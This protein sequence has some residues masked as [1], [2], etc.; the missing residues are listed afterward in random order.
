[1][2]R[3]KK[4]DIE[5]TDPVTAIVDA[6]NDTKDE[7]RCVSLGEAHRV[8]KALS[9]GSLIADL[10]LGG[11]FQC[12]RLVHIYGPEAS[13]KSTFLQACAIS[14]QKLDIPIVHYDTEHSADPVYMRTQGL[15][16]HKTIEIN[17]KNVPAY[18]YAQPETGEGVYKHLH[19][20]LRR[21][22]DVNL[23][24]INKPSCLILLDSVAAMFSKSRDVET[25]EGAAGLEARMHSR[26][27]GVTK[28]LLA[29]KGA[30]MIASNQ[31]RMNINMRMPGANPEAPTGGQ[32][33]KYYPDY[34]IR[35]HGRKKAEE[36]KVGMY[37]Q[38][39]WV[40]TIKNKTFPAF[41][42]FEL[43]IIMGKGIDKA[44]D[45]LDFLEAI[46][47][48][49]RKQGKNKILLKKFFTD[50]YLAWDAFRKVAESDEFRN[51]CFSLLK[52]DAVYRRH[53]KLLGYKNY[54]LDGTDDSVEVEGE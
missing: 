16:I 36:D 8:D 43:D 1:M 13:G 48:V 30:I 54:A 33:W 20:F 51:Y 32:A 22:P 19:R 3:K 26:F 31:I 38:H 39:V 21:L 15:D 46:G 44:Q 11:G 35:V 7:I 6:F 14:G 23:H 2:P 42:E 17:G 34:A 10:K 28:S 52:K 25:G 53:F 27:L 9:T 40:R 49:E 24:D 18:F 37:R 47:M 12:G 41:Q 50:K 4:S 29:H 45:G 5:F